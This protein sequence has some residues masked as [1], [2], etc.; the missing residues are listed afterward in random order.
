MRMWRSAVVLVVTVATAL[1]ITAAPA[2]GARARFDDPADDA[3]RGVD[4]LSVQVVNDDRV[5]VRTTFD[6]LRR[7]G[8]TGLAVFIDTVRRN[9]GPEYLAGGGLFEGTDFALSRIDG[10]NDPP[11]GPLSCDID[12]RI[13]FRTGVAT[14]DIARRCLRRPDAIRVSLKAD[15]GPGPNDWAPRRRVFFPPVAHG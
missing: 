1:S 15:D 2:S 6:R 7:H 10:F 3:R 13:H 11:Q 5:I 14:F 12:L 9:R 8:S 4:I